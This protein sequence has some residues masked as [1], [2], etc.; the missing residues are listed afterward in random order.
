LSY[1]DDIAEAI[2]RQV[3]PD[4]LPDGD[5]A[6]LFRTYAVLALA[7]GEAVTLEDVHNAWSA[8]MSPQDPDHPSLKPLDE[9]S[10]DVRRADEPYAEA[11]RA[12][13]RIRGR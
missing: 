2:R 6:Q 7:K 13:G 11:I 1:I 10:A 9:L 5:S 3:S 12:V 8:W 4:L